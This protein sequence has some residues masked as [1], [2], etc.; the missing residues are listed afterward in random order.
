[1]LR[2]LATKAI[3]SYFANTVESAKRKYLNIV[4]NIKEYM[5]NDT[6]TLGLYSIKKY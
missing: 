4:K 1:M 6:F 5:Q 2:Q 3:L